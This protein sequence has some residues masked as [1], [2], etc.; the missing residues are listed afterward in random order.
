MNE[1]YIYLFLSDRQKKFFFGVPHNFSNWFMCAMEW[2]R[3]K[4]AALE[5]ILLTKNIATF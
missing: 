1:N 2:K 4:I 3:L 5:E